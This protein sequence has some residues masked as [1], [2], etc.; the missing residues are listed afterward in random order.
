MKWIFAIAL[1]ALTAALSQAQETVVN[2]S[3]L[4]HLTERIQFNSD[5]VD[6]IHI[7]ADYPSYNW[8][9]ASDEGIACVDDAG[10]AAV[11]YL[12]HY[13]LTKDRSS[14][15]RAKELLK[16]VLYLQAEDGQ[17]YNFIY[18]DRSINR[19]GIT[20][21]KS[22]GWWAARGIWCFG[23]G[24]RIF[25][26]EDPQFA[27]R[28]KNGIQKTFFHLDTLLRHYKKKKT[29]AGYDIPQWLLYESGAD[30]TTELVLGLIEYYKAM[31]DVK[32]KEYIEKLCEG[33]M[34]MQDGDANTFPYGVHSSWETMWRMGERAD[35]GACRSGEVIEEQKDDR[36]CPA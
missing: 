20:S 35:A 30:A 34:V 13:E 29:V 17:F 33:M 9:D 7:Y 10:R 19:S 27:D 5:S 24:Y 15:T 23:M 21:Y 25:E 36:V 32:V 16:F 12:R 4:R 28:L 22:L 2:F 8:V 14:M 11:A 31:D 1:A 6:I 26:R 18:A 3:H